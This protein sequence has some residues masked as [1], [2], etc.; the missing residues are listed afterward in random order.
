M[1]SW[2]VMLSRDSSLSYQNIRKFA[3]IIILFRH[4]SSKII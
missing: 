4:K 2:D 3:E 1:L